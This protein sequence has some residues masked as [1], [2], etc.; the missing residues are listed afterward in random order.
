VCRYIASWLPE[1]RGRACAKAAGASYASCR[2]DAFKTE[3]RKGSDKLL[4]KRRAN[5][6]QVVALLLSLA[7]VDIANSVPSRMPFIS[8]RYVWYS[9][10][11]CKPPFTFIQTEKISECYYDG[12]DSWT[13]NC[14]TNGSHIL[15]T[16]YRSLTPGSHCTG[17]PTN[18]TTIVAN[19][20]SRLNA[21]GSHSSKSIIHQCCTNSNCD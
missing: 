15:R 4:L 9:T 3:A 13:N 19:E 21:S 11:D 18:T 10:P 6:V 12:P 17:T 16:Y 5:M 14:S 1:V 8:E 20:C 7:L 2:S